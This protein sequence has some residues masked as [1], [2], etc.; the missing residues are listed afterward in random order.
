M[1]LNKEELINKIIYRSSYRGTKEMDSLL[2]SFVKSII[3]D[4]N[5]EELLKL[6]EFVNL[7]DETL[8]KIRTKDFQKISDSDNYI[9]NKFKKYNF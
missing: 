5:Y 3:Y 4:L 2:K 1:R 6:N 8:Y 7:D 9:F